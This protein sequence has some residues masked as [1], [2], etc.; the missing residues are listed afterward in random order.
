MPQLVS[1]TERQGALVRG[2]RVVKLVKQEVNGEGFASPGVS[3]SRLL[4][5]PQASRSRR[6]LP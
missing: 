2:L 1:V 4:T 3:H 6:P 5:E